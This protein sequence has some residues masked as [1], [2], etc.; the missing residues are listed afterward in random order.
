M[1]AR[2]SSRPS[3]PWYT[4]RLYDEPAKP[5]PPG[6]ENLEDPDAVAPLLA[7]IDYWRNPL[8][9]KILYRALGK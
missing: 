2:P 4:L 1:R 8:L 6:V 9:F 7:H 5:A 3:S